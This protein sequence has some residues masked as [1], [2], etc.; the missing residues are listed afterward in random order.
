[1]KPIVIFVF[2]VIMTSCKNKE[3][4]PTYLGIVDFEVTGKAQAL[5]L[6]EK[7]LLLL[8]S[9]EYQ[10]AREAFVE[11][12]KLD[13][14]MAMAYWGEAMTYNHSLW[15]EQDYQDGVA[16]VEKIDLINATGLN[17]VEKDLLEAIK[18][19]YKP[20]TPKNERDKSYMAFMKSLYDKYPDQ[21]EIAAFYALSLLGSVSE[22][23]NDSIYGEGATVANKIL[24]KNAKH[25]GALHY[26]IHS[27][28]DPKHAHLALDAANSYAKV[29]PDASHALHMPSHIYVALGMWDKVVASNIDSYGASLKRM[30]DKGLDNDARGYHAYHWLEY[31]YLQKEQVEEAEKMV[32]DMQKY[33][34]EKPSKRARAHLLFLKGTFLA[35][36]DLWGHAIANVE[37]DITGMNISV[38]AQNY[39]IEGMK[40]FKNKE[41]GT[42]NKIIGGLEGEIK[43]ESLLVDNISNGGSLCAS[44]ERSLPNRTDVKR[45]EVMNTQLLGLAAWL[46]EELDVAE[47]F[48]KTSVD[49]EDN[50][51]Y[52]YGPP[53]ILMPTKELYAKFLNLQGRPQEALAL[54]K[55]ALARGPKR[56]IPL[57]GIEETTKLMA[58]S[59][60]VKSQI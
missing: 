38:K 22:G 28:D 13:A 31:G 24:E 44:S 34:K 43:Q 5:Q 46:K 47:Q 19:L 55:A 36:T 48:F 45:A 2:L 49:L 16:A 32:W 18:I 37:I 4:S 33:C 6:F 58:S 1:M 23:R 26:L 15:R 25:P 27:Y 17:P 50:V 54:Y 51:P 8:H 11:A 7:G 10:D 40:A 53:D 52:S 57:K 39:F 12:Q 60:L 41:V 29:A 21:N 56:L 59:N 14:N 30:R 42:L 9:F 35:E 20:K 3:E